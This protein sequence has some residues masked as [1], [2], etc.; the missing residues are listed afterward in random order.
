MARPGELWGP[1]LGAAHKVFLPGESPW[2]R[3]VAIHDDGTWD[4]TIE[5][6]LFA[7]MP[8]TERQKVWSG[9]PLPRLHDYHRG[10]TIRF[11]RKRTADY[12]IWIPAERAGGNA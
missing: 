1:T 11:R 4:G 8:E 7:E 12:E 5:N 2:A 3:C 6:T 10:N 9:D